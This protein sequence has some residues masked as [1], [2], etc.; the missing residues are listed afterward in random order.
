MQLILTAGRVVEKYVKLEN[1]NEVVNY[2]FPIFKFA[3][4]T[5]NAGYKRK[6]NTDEG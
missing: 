3:T 1:K 6:M 4:Q 5:F 2:I